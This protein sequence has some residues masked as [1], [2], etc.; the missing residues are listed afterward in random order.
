MPFASSKIPKEYF[1]D[2]FELGLTH[3]IGAKL[4]MY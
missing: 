2:P 3:D 4:S 1:I